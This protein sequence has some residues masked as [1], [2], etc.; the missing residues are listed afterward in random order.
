MSA[1][2][3]ERLQEHLGRLR[4]FKSRERVEALPAAWNTPALDWFGRDFSRSAL[5][6]IHEGFYT[7]EKVLDFNPNV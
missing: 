7:K 4:L 1:A 2:Q 5:R 3:L 6:A